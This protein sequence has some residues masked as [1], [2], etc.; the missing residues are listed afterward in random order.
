MKEKT[1]KDG[2]YI[3]SLQANGSEGLMTAYQTQHGLAYPGGV[4]VRA[5][6]RFS[7]LVLA[8]SETTFSTLCWRH[9]YSATLVFDTFKKMPNV[10]FDIS[11]MH[12]H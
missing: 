2:E 8:E 3:K 4:T 11:G 6:P 9:L 12:V 1:I 5:F 7:E 10:I